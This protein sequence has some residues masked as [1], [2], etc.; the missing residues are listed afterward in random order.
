MLL[1][2]CAINVPANHWGKKASEIPGAW[3]VCTDYHYKTIK[4][5]N[6]QVMGSLCWTILKVNLSYCWNPGARCK[7]WLLNGKPLVG[8]DNQKH[9]VLLNN[10]TALW[11]GLH[12]QTKTNVNG[13]GS[14]FHWKPSRYTLIAYVCQ[15]WQIQRWTSRSLG[16]DRQI[17]N[18]WLDK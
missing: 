1:S 18:K 15:T 9:S 2:P 3:S 4:S 11:F 10:T 13:S 5:P 7:P 17:I 16:T 14:F 12:K 6:I 8:W